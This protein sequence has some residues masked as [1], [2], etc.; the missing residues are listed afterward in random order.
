LP[1]LS[2]RSHCNMQRTRLGDLREP[3]RSLTGAR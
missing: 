3:I 2:G 1:C